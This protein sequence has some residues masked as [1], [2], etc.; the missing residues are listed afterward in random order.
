LLLW[1]VVALLA[2]ARVTAAQT[3]EVPHPRSDARAADSHHLRGGWYPWDPYQYRE[4]RHGVSI[5]TGFDVEIERAL[6]RILRVEILLP[7]MPWDEH[8]AALA[9]GRADIAAGA[10]ASPEREAFAYV[11]KPYR[12]ET[13]VLIL[14]KGASSRYPFRTIEQML[15]MFARQKFRLGVIAGYAYAD[16]RV[17]DFVTDPAKQGA[18]RRGRNR[19]RQSAQSPRRRDRRLS[20]RPCCGEHHRLAQQTGRPHRGASAAFLG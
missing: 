16:E 4:Y 10:T 7:Q 12:T 11:S 6:A 5:L 15:D 3:P 14:P 13:D 2:S 9:D 18:D 17:H 8:L 19:R 20:R 1:L